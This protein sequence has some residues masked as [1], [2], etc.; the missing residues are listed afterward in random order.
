MQLEDAKSGTNDAKTNPKRMQKLTQLQLCYL[1]QNF[2]K[3]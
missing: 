2:E 3:K 1:H